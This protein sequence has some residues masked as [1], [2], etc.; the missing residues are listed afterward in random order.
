MDKPVM[1]S[2]DAVISG[3]FAVYRNDRKTRLWGGGGK[4]PERTQEAVIVSMF[5]AIK[6]VQTKNT[7]PKRRKYPCLTTKT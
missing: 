2:L 1:M 5:N 4:S 3:S 6:S 7:H